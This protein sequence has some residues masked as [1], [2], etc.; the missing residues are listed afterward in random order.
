MSSSSSYQPTGF[1]TTRA[2]KRLA[3]DLEAEQPCSVSNHDTSTD[4]KNNNDYSYS[5]C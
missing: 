3:F 2:P 1:A 5:Q 4:Y